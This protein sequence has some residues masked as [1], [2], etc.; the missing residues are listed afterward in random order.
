MTAFQYLKGVTRKKGIGS[1]A[2]SVVTEH[3]EMA[4]CL[5][6]VDLYWI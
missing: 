3:G 6:E 1:S 5:K 4:S 2:V